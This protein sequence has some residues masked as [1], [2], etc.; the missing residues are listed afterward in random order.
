[1]NRGL[2]KEE[3]FHNDREKYFFLKIL[4]EKS[5]AKK[6]RILA[7]CI[8]SNHYHLIVQNTSGNLSDFMKDLNGQFGVYYR[9]ITGGKG[10][11]FEGRFKSTIIQ[12]DQYLQT[13]VLYIFLNPVRGG[14]VKDPWSYPWSS[15]RD[16]FNTNT[17]FIDKKYVEDMFLEKKKLEELLHEWNER[18]L[19]VRRNREGDCLGDDNFIE[20]AVRIFNRRKKIL[21]SKRMRTNELELEPI[22]NILMDFETLRGIS[23]DDINVNSRNGRALRDEL[24][25]LL[26]DKAGLSYS[27]IIQCTPFQNLKYSSLGQMYRRTKEKMNM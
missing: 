13:A 8:M 15:L 5:I 22:D 9:K 25:V 26:K 18:E 14:L 7:Y 4:E 23:I 6:I 10:Y 21:R 3:I 16:Y 24:L 17:T 19:P 2:L 27:E 12:E 20:S 11:V 1:M